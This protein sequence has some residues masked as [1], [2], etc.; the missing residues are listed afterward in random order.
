[1]REVGA[2]AVALEPGAPSGQCLSFQ[3]L[4]QRIGIECADPTLRQIL[5]GNFGAFA[6]ESDDAIRDLAYRV[7]CRNASSFTILRDGR[8]PLQGQAPGDFLYLLEKDITVELQ[9]RRSDLLFLHSAAVELQGGA[10]LLAAESGSGKSTTTWAL[11]H[12]QFRYLSD[13]LS[14][15]DLESM[16]VFPYP[17]ALCLKQ[18]PG[19]DY[20]LPVDAIHLGRTIHVP[21]RSL[22]AATI[23]DPLPLRAVIL[24]KYMPHLSAPQ[25]RALGPA[26]AGARLYINA[27]NSLAHPN[28]GLD[29]VMRITEHVPCFTLSTTQLL[30]T[31]TLLRSA[32]DLQ[33]PSEH[34]RA[35]ASN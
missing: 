28:H 18:A 12:H 10:C 8:P 16:R 30:A 17:H 26:E 7:I 9:K 24:L 4:D 1:V 34:P 13:E 3:I 15:V 20:A 32:L 33:V 5:V 19:S 35:V 2:R 11:L 22:P 21:A 14:P 25:L 23:L 31:C 29:A 6:A 27:L